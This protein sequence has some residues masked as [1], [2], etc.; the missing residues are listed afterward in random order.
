MVSTKIINNKR[1]DTIV[2]VLIAILVVGTILGGAYVAANRYFKNVRQA[3][4]YTTAIKIAEG[5]IEQI[6][7]LAAK[8]DTRPFSQPYPFCLLNGF[9]QD[10]NIAANCKTSGG[11]PYKIRI[12]R[13]GDNNQGYTFV[14]NVSWSN[15]NG[16][17]DSQ[18]A[19][20]YRL[21]QK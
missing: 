4:E 13:S 1:G 20:R 11:V 21:F 17:S 3:Q 19:I 6:K 10:A 15:I 5:Q 18:A 16:G 9:F 14:I 12:N 2:E 8:S 7:S